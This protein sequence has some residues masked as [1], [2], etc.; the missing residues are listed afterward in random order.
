VVANLS[1]ELGPREARLVPDDQARQ[2]GI[3]YDRAETAERSRLREHSIAKDDPGRQYNCPLVFVTPNR[4]PTS[5]DRT[6]L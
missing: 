3:K 1:A 6:R 2:A 4:R 5:C